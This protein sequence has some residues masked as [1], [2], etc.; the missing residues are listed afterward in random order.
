MSRA[1]G[2]IASLSE[3]NLKR[4]RQL[5]LPSGQDLARRMGLPVLSAALLRTG[6]HGAILAGAGF[7]M[8]GDEIA[9]GGA[10]ALQFK[11]RR[12][13]DNKNVKLLTVGRGVSAEALEARDVVFEGVLDVGGV[14]RLR[15]GF[16]NVFEQ[17][18]G[19]VAEACF[20]EGLRKS[21]GDER[22]GLLG[23]HEI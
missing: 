5:G 1:P 17:V 13:M 3:R 20:V 9:D 10:G 19:E 12:Q 8:V 14:P 6:A 22:A 2:E 7:E 11:L 16:V 15:L 18:D 4:G 21:L 23:I